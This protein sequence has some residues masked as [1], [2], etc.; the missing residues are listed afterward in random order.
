MKIFCAKLILLTQFI[1]TFFILN[2]VNLSI[3][4]FQMSTK[5][6]QY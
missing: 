5:G 4:P 6:Y 3:N 2:C 1:S